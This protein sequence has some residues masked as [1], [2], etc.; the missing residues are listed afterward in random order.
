MFGV[1]S[2]VGLDDR[3]NGGEGF[4]PAAGRILNRLGAGS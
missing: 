3:G 2:H 4:K 1:L